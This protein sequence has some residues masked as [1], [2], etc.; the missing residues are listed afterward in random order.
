MISH[1]LEIPI[2][3]IC[4][5]LKCYYSEAGF[6]FISLFHNFHPSWFLYN[7]C[8]SYF[9][10]NCILQ[11]V[12]EYTLTLLPI[13]AFASRIGDPMVV[14]KSLQIQRPTMVLSPFWVWGAARNISTIGLEVIDPRIARFLKMCMSQL[15]MTFRM[16][17][18]F[19]KVALGLFSLM[20]QG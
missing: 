4:S 13:S 3:F 2:T 11:R 8:K 19:R 9:W 12:Q 5:V 1:C 20:R 18:Q 6:H 10:T 7:G 16:L 14:T 15:S 17:R